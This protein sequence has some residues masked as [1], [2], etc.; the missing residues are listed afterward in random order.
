[1]R[2]LIDVFIILCLFSIPVLAQGPAIKMTGPMGIQGNAAIL[3]YYGISLSGTAHTLTAPEYAS[4]FLLVTSSIPLTVTGSIIGPLT[5]GQQFTVENNTTGGQSI[6]IIGATGTGVVILNGKTMAVVSDGVNYVNSAGSSSGAVTSV[7]VVSANGVS[8]TV[9]TPTS[10]PAIT[11]TLGDINP[12]SIGFKTPAAGFFT[13]L[14]STMENDLLP[15]GTATSS[16]NSNSAS[17]AF[18]SSYWTGSAA[19]NDYW[20]IT[21]NPGGGSNPTSTLEFTHLGSSGAAVVDFPALTIAHVPV[22][23]ATNGACNNVLFVPYANLTGP[24]PAWN[25]NTTGTAATATLATSATNLAALPVLCPTGQSPTGILANGNATGCAAAGGAVYPTGSG[26]PIV[27]VGAWGTTVAAPVGAVVGTTDTQTLTNKTVDGVSPTTLAFVDPTSSVQTQLNGKAAA[28]TGTGYAYGNGASPYTFSLTIPNAGLTNSSMNLN[29]VNVALGQTIVFPTTCGGSGGICPYQQVNPV[30]SGGVTTTTAAIT[31][32]TTAIPVTSCAGFTFAPGAI[33]AFVNNSSIE[34]VVASGC[35]GTTLT[36][37]TRG[38]YF[39]I[40]DTVNSGP[41][42]WASGTSVIQMVAGTSLSTAHAPNSYVLANG[43]QVYG[44]GSYTAANTL[45]FATQGIFYSGLTALGAVTLG[46]GSSPIAYTPQAG[47]SSGA[48]SWSSGC[49]TSG[50]SYYI[51]AGSYGWWAGASGSNCPNGTNLPANVFAIVP[52]TLGGGPSPSAIPALIV[53]RLGNVN[54]PAGGSYKVNGTPVVTAVP[55]IGSMECSGNSYIYAAGSSAPALYGVCSILANDIAGVSPINY[56]SNG[57]FS[58]QISISVLANHHFSAVLPTLTLTNIVENDANTSACGTTVGSNCIKNMQLAEEAVLAWSSIPQTFRAMA[59]TLTQ[60]SG[61]TAAGVGLYQNPNL[62]SSGLALQSSAVGNTLSYTTPVSWNASPVIGLT[63]YVLNSGIGP[64]TLSIGGVLQTDFCSGTT[65][66]AST[67]C[68]GQSLSGGT[69]GIFRQEFAVTPGSQHT[70]ILTTTS[71][72][73]TVPV[74]LDAIPPS[75]NTNTGIVFVANSNANYDSS[76]N[77]SAAQAVIANQLKADGLPVFEVNINATTNFTTDVSTTATTTCA[78]S[79]SAGHF[80][81]CGNYHFY[82]GI[83]ATEIANNYQVGVPNSGGKAVAQSGII[84]TPL[85]IATGVQAGYTHAQTFSNSN[86]LKQNYCCGTDVYNASGYITGYGGF[87]NTDSSSGYPWSGQVMV[88][89]YCSQNGWFGIRQWSGVN[90]QTIPQ[91]DSQF[92]TTFG[93]GCATGRSYQLGSNT[94]PIFETIV[95]GAIASATTI[96]PTNGIMHITGTAAIATI[97]PP[98]NMS[99]TVGG[100][101]TMI[102][103]SG[104][105]TTIAGNI[106]AVYTFTAGQ[107]TS[108]CYDGSKWYF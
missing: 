73:P 94:A 74:S 22:C 34:W 42:A 47:F 50:P 100:C 27:A 101:V 72:T 3:G 98:T 44:Q 9:G 58:T 38:Y 77:F 2:K 7:S 33:M 84:N 65:T 14:E 5:I 48:I 51:A 4:N 79:A 70:I 37:T 32:S 107:K 90:S 17:M 41:I 55:E 16:S 85:S 53:D 108:A 6:Q 93:V 62:A 78:A 52:G 76:G 31:I 61:W 92:Q 102:F 40:G 63:Y 60:S 87:A 80:N 68:N 45:N 13:R 23:S 12:S 54:V 57:T 69:A 46:G 56:A 104:L 105:S 36:A 86:T 89:D 43:A 106:F 28:T 25:Q 83:L 39:T 95:G 64:F 35:T 97:T 26:I 75:T 88:F 24:V 15:L 49:Q 1:M 29:G 103:D 8:G 99:A 67:G 66:F 82:Q 20:T 10:T 18:W 11:L 30:T 59:S 96:A 19:S 21:S 81:D 91:T 71:T